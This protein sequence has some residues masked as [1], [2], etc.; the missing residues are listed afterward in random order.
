[1]VGAQDLA[2]A[3]EAYY[4]RSHSWQGVQE[5]LAVTGRGHGFGM[6]N[7]GMA[8]MMNQRLR[9]AD[10]QGRLVA[11]T[12]GGVTG[13]ILNPDDLGKAIPLQVKGQTV[14]Y[15]LPENGMAFNPS[16]EVFLAGRI[17]RAALSAGLIAAGLSLVLAWLLSYRLL[18]PVNALTRA[19]GKMSQGDLT[20][21]VEVHGADE[22]ALLGKTFN[23]MAE[24]LQRA[25]ESRQA[26]TADIAHEL[27]NPLAVQRASLEALQD[28]VYPLTPENLAPI[29]EQNKLLSHLV[30]DLRTLALADSGQLKLEIVPTDL[31]ALIQGVVERFAPQAA[32]QQVELSLYPSKSP[33]PA[34][35]LDPLRVQQILGNLLSNALRYTPAQ[36]RVEIQLSQP[37]PAVEI[38][39]HDSGS[40]IPSD[41]LPHI[42]ERFYRADKSRSRAEGGTGLGLAIARQL[43]QAHGGSLTAGNP[44]EGGALFTLT[45][46]IHP[47]P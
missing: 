32:M 13:A 44:P 39:V 29:L 46:P 35:T 1:M 3:L 17:S 14:G 37:G 16:D 23:R 26:M 42:F 25:E 18:R 6:G 43:A 7:S 12:Q 15:L 20:Q 28:G 47:S 24:S 33:I 22:L 10:A 4:A 30:D 27:R 5:V 40:G 38:T 36:G 9:L 8:G 31:S 21:R 19:S 2:G 41:A 34:V 45:L 11:D